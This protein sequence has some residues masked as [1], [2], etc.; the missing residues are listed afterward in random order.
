MQVK[1]LQGRHLT[2]TERRHICQLVEQNLERGGTRR[3]SY[4]RLESSGTQHRIKI[5]TP[6][7]DSWGRA[8]ISTQTVLVDVR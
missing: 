2:T 3:K 5:E 1:L 4:T 8:V 7:R 6:E